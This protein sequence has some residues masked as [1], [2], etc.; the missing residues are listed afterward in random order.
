MIRQ[1]DQT[2]NKVKL[3]TADMDKPYEKFL[4][5]GADNLSDAELLAIIIRTGTRD[6]D[7][8][9][10]GQKVL[11]L[12][13]S[14]LGL[15]G[16][17]HISVDELMTIKGIGEVKA[18]KI[19]CVAELSR[20]LSKTSAGL[21]LQIGNP[22]TVANYYMEDMRHQESEWIM[23]VMLDNKNRIIKDEIISKGTVNASLLSPREIFLMSLRYKAVYILILHNHPSG[24]PTPSKQDIA[25]TERIREVA[26]LIGIPLIDHIIIGDRKYMSFK[27]K[28]FLK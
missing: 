28:G 19:K 20:R 12:S 1:N 7:S 10:I 24:D 14:R 5:L 11:D 9:T 2:K 8:V 27:E 22:K 25:I 26:D 13:D 17:H 18:V 3:L 4:R 21:S 16:I 15:L 6:A 23:L